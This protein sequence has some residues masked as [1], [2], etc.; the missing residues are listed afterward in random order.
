MSIRKCI[1]LLLILMLIG[2]WN[3][4]IGQIASGKLTGKVYDEISHDPLIGATIQLK[5]LSS[6][7][8]VSDTIGSFSMYPLPVGRYELVSAYIGYSTYHLIIEIKSGKQEMIEIGMLPSI[9]SL[10][11]ITINGSSTLQH[12]N[13]MAYA[14]TRTFGV[15]QTSRFAGAVDDPAR[16]VASYPGITNGDDMNNYISIR[17]NNPS[18]LL[19]RLEGIDIPNPNH[20]AYT[21]ATGG[22][23]SA[24]SSQ[25]ISS[26]DFSTGAFAA[27]FGNS[28]GGVFDVRLRKGNNEKREFAFKAGMLGAEASAEGPIKKSYGGSYLINMRASTLALFEK[29]GLDIFGNATFNDLAYNIHFPIKPKSSISIFGMN[30]RSI[31][32]S[33]D[34]VID[35]LFDPRI[36]S[37]I[38]EYS[39]KSNLSMHAVKY[40]YFHKNSAL[41][42]TFALSGTTNS[43][44]NTKKTVFADASFFFDKYTKKLNTS[45]SSLILSYQ[46]Q[47]NSSVLFKSGIHFDVLGYNIGTKVYTDD[48]AFNSFISENGSSLFTQAYT[49]IK[50]NTGITSVNAGLHFSHLAFN[51]SSSL[52]PRLNVE[53]KFSSIDNVS[54]SYGRHSQIHP[55]YIYFLH[56]PVSNTWNNKSLKMSFSDHYVLGYERILPAHFKSKLEIYFQ[57]LKNI[58]TGAG[59]NKYY[60]LLNLSVDYPYF[61]LENRGRGINKGI[62]FSLEKSFNRSW[63]GLWSLSIFDSKYKNPQTN[64]LNTQFNANYSFVVTVG[65][66][67]YI[68]KYKKNKLGFNLKSTY[69]GGMRYIPIDLEQSRIE[70]KVIYKWDDSYISQLPDYFKSDLGLQFRQNGKKYNSLWSLDIWNVSNKRNIGG[71]EF[72]P[73]KGDYQYWYQLPILPIFSFKLEF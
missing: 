42:I 49:Q 19:W 72:I 58:P 67:W 37:H 7:S 31:T 35:S 24:L 2:K 21:G 18:A 63:Y 54:L 65:K 22:A 16:M 61:S 28:I 51:N 66:E 1:V 32:K 27:E 45:K 26:A 4:T 46:K 10:D 6:F 34:F 62:E 68:G 15:E 44:I 56:A 12:A 50:Y 9:S 71:Q 38:S 70:K 29:A 11:Q 40:S 53:L 48:K 23:I 5:G 36:K 13:T 8:S 52:E 30:A 41:G 69:S 60:S 59:E 73:I 47:I 57:N 55:L 20:F 17:G 33:K 39:F 14:T 25:L 3:H 43:T 64:W